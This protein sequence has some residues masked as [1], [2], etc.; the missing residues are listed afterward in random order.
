[1]AKRALSDA[2]PVRDDDLVTW[3]VNLKALPEET[4]TLYQYEVDQQKLQAPYARMVLDLIDG[5]D[6]DESTLR[7]I[8]G[9]ELWLSV[10]R[11]IRNKSGRLAPPPTEEV[12]DLA[13]VP[14]PGGGEIREEVRTVGGPAS[15]WTR[16][17]FHVDEAEAVSIVNELKQLLADAGWLVT[18]DSFERG[19]NYVCERDARRLGVRVTYFGG[20]LEIAYT[21]LR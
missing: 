17:D 13:D 14:V 21:P 9:R 7:A 8:G 3:V 5:R 11:G 6:P 2:D 16:Y 20:E 1:M 18:L 19:P 12:P 10:Y 15:E 4:A